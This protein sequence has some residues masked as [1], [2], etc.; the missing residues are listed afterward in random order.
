[1]CTYVCIC[2]VCVSPTH[3]HLSP[4]KHLMSGFPP[5]LLVSWKK[6][7]IKAKWQVT[8]VNNQACIVTS[9]SF[10]AWGR[11]R[12]RERRGAREKHHCLNYPNIHLSRNWS[13][14]KATIVVELTFYK[15]TEHM[16]QSKIKWCLDKG[17]QWIK[18]CGRLV[19]T[20]WDGLI[21]HQCFF[22]SSCFK[23]EAVAKWRL[24]I[25]IC[26]K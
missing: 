5:F 22:S 15:Q 18:D 14:A 9:P 2:C 23:T 6:D 11:K 12:E 1:M 26:E 24:W 8:Q 4:S 20:W 3:W 16:A 21:S 7:P 19:F 17:S 10:T 25:K 13:L